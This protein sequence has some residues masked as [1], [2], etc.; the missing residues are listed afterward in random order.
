MGLEEDCKNI[1]SFSF[2][3]SDWEPKEDSI[4]VRHRSNDRKKACFSFEMARLG[5]LSDSRWS[6]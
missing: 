6:A 2:R 1:I 5:F 4:Q 3:F